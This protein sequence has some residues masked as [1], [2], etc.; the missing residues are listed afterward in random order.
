M[1]GKGRSWWAVGLLCQELENTEGCQMEAVAPRQRDGQAERGVRL[2]SGGKDSTQVT[3]CPQNHEFPWHG[4]VSLGEGEGSKGQGTRPVAEGKRRKR[5]IGRRKSPTGL[6]ETC[7]P[8]RVGQQLLHSLPHSLP[9]SSSQCL[10]T[11][12]RQGEPGARSCWL[13]SLW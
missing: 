3:L 6:P 8:G 10:L 4:G 12:S 5:E 1:S 13:A 2:P 7:H 11:A 9:P